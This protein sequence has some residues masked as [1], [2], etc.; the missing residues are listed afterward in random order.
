MKIHEGVVL[1]ISNLTQ[2][3]IHVPDNIT[4]KKLL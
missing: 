2:T 1:E 3:L 4:N